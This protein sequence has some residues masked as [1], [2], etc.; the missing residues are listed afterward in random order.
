M[1]YDSLLLFSPHLSDTKLIWKIELLVKIPTGSRHQHATNLE[2][3]HITDLL[4]LR[5]A[6]RSS[7]RNC[8][9]L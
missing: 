5:Q 4:M 3:P 1:Q 9:R 8:G 7:T 6:N 2:E